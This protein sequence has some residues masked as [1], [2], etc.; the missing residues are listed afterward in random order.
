MSWFIRSDD[1][2]EVMLDIEIVPPRLVDL[3]VVLSDTYN[4][5]TSDAI[6]LCCQVWFRRKT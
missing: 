4:P 3:V 5:K 2:E 1:T 6:A